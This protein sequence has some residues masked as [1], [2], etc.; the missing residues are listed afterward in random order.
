MAHASVSARIEGM[1]GC[2]STSRK[3]VTLPIT[4]WALLALVASGALACTPPVASTVPETTEVLYVANA[5]AGTISRHDAWSGRAFGQPLP[6]GVAPARV[7]PGP[8]G[9]LVVATGV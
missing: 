7:V 2:L 3:L 9:L 5:R 1:F 4:G 8:G 6:A